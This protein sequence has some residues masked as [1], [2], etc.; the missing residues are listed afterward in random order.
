MGPV[1]TCS[2]VPPNSRMADQNHQNQQVAN[3]S[4]NGDG[5]FDMSD[6]F[7]TRNPKDVGAGLSSGL[8]SFGKGLA[9]GL[10]SLVALPVAKAR[11]E[12]AVGFAKG[13]GLGILS[14]V[15]LTVAGA[16][17]GVVQIGRGIA[18]T[19]GAIKAKMD[20]KVWDEEKRVWILYNLKEEAD[21]VLKEDLDAQIISSKV[22]EREF[23]D[24]LGVEPTATNS[25]IKKAYRQRAIILHP[26]K[27]PNDANA[28]ENFQKL[29]NAYQVL[30]NPELRK[31]Y[32]LRGKDGLD[33]NSLMDSAQLFE[34]IFGSQ[35]III[36]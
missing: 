35:V 12:G 24:L 18:N 31:N 14:A 25:E 17:T 19:P 27:N 1:T 32:D 23:Y 2:V 4:N 11:E 8:K 5:E 16:G 10:V 33:E 7:S 29:G 20:D 9:G 22:K 13:L 34:V 36:D 21:I 28:S 6:V 15:T 26:D 3:I 30:S